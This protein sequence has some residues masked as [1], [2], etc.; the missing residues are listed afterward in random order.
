MPDDAALTAIHGRGPRDTRFQIG[1]RARTFVPD[2]VAAL[3]AAL[4]QITEAHLREHLGL[5]VM[6]SLDVAGIQWTEE[7]PDVFETMLIVP[8]ERLRLFFRLA[9]RAGQYVLAVVT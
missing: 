1:Y 9:A 3:S 5:Q 2:E 4:D 7:G 8:F 6:E